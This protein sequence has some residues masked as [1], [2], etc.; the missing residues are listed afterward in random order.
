MLENPEW[1]TESWTKEQKDIAGHPEN[2]LRHRR[3]LVVSVDK[4]N[5]RMDAAQLKIDK[6]AAKEYFNPG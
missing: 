3:K 4:F 6:T 1:F 5:R 2:R